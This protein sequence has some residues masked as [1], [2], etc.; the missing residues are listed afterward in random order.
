MI[1]VGFLC[2]TALAVH[3]V[4]GNNADNAT[5]SC[6]AQSTMPEATLHSELVWIES[7]AFTMGSNA[8]YPE[9]RSEQVVTVSG[10]WIDRHEVTNAQFAE[11]VAETGYVT[12]AER[13]PKQSD[14]PDIP[15][16]LLEPGAAVFTPPVD[17]RTGGVIQWWRFVAGANWR[18]PAGTNS[19]IDGL[20]RHPVVQ[21]AYE[22][23]LAYAKW[24]GRDLPTEAQ[25]EFAAR[26]GNDEPGNNLAQTPQRDGEWIANTWQGIFPVQNTRDD[27]YHGSAP[28]GCFP[29]NAYGLYDMIGNVWELTADAYTPNHDTIPPVAERP[30]RVT[31]KGG[32]FLCAPN[33]CARYRPSAR[34]AQDA[35]LGASNV[36]FRTVLN[37]TQDHTRANSSF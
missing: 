4:A 2:I 22:D 35:D 10:F 6:E 14:H 33:Y 15:A 5:V 27:G 7:G 13:Q 9:E 37:V 8:H 11:F 23:A 30:F 21:V 18:R 26:A 1:A 32:S 16:N 34:Q 28:I 31:I 36:G 17:P 3:T 20:D 19:S 12:V 24:K 29:P 25:W